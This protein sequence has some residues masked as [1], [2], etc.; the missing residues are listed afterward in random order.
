MVVG[1]DPGP[2]QSAFVEYSPHCRPGDRGIVSNELLLGR[3]GLI[4]QGTVLAV[5]MVGVAGMAGNSI[6][7]T[8]VWIG[9][10]CERWYL[11]H[12]RT[13]AVRIKRTAVKMH[14]LGS[15]RG[16]DALV[17]D[18]LIDRFSGGRGAGYALGRA[19]TP[20]PLFGI[21]SHVWAALAVAVTCADTILQ[22]QTAPQR[23]LPLP[24]VN[25]R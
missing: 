6:F 2:V 21:K 25:H 18:A 19:D 8:C 4:P 3:I 11:T 24:P 5:E 20:G 22:P 1:I 15:T 14:L 7:E 17:R 16:D 12:R 13:R 23:P 10:F 9:H